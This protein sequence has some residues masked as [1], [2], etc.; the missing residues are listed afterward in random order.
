M[1]GGH[2]EVSPWDMKGQARGL[3]SVFAWL[4]HQ[5]EKEALNSVNSEAQGPC[6]MKK[7][8]W[9]LKEADVSGAKT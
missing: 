9:G 3:L 1:T 4:R 6:E 5:I 2:S 7:L 8:D